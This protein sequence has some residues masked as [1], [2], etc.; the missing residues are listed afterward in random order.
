MEEAVTPLA[1]LS[2]MQE[3]GVDLFALSGKH[4]YMMVDKYSGMPLHQLLHG[5][6]TRDATNAMEAFCNWFGWPEVVHADYGPCFR[7]GFTTIY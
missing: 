1:E 7:K 2:L 5:E 4:Y 6:M 3:V